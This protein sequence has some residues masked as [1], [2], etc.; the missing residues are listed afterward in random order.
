MDNFIKINN[1][2]LAVKEFKGQRVITFK[3]IDTLHERPEGTAN[4]RFLDNKKHFEKDMDYF[5]FLGDELKQIKQL[6][7]FGIG[8]NANKFILI[9]ESGYLMLVK[10]LTDDLAW[11]VQRELVNNYFRRKNNLENLSKELQAIFAL[12]KKQQVLEKDISLVK[13]D[14]ADMK[15]NSPLYTIECKEIQ[16]IVKKVGTRTLGGHGSKVYNNRSLRT[17]VYSD[18]QCQLRRE[19]GVKRYEAIKRCQF[20]KAKEIIQAYKA[21]TVLGDQITLENNQIGM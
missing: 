1:Q 4:K 8:S 19:F 12:D 20:E 6:P 7:N 5:E 21:P 18:I 10:S 11:K 3:D 14:V 15:L 13:E 2:E 9:T 17:K 16:D